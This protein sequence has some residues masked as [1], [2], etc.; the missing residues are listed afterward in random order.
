[1][2][3]SEFSAE[4]FR[5]LMGQ[6]EVRQGKDDRGRAKGKRR[7][8]HD[9]RERWIYVRVGVQDTGGSEKFYLLGL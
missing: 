6:G 5:P 7:R 9:G 1:M 3:W 4:I 2:L 8:D